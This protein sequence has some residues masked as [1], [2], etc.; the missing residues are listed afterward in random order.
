[1]L[2]ASVVQECLEVAAI[3]CEVMDLNLESL[4][5]ALFVET[6][7]IM[8]SREVFYTIFYQRRVADCLWDIELKSHTG[9]LVGTVNLLNRGKG[10]ASHQHKRGD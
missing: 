1:M 3:S 9:G 4:D 8:G 2:L 5:K 10:S 7:G 6:R